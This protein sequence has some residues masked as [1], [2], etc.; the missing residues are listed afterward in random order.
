MV[1]NNFL[2]YFG[3]LIYF[4]LGR[5]PFCIFYKY[6]DS[7]ESWAS[8]SGKQSRT[9]KNLSFDSKENDT[10]ANDIPGNRASR[11]ID[12]SSL[13]SSWFLCT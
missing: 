2:L 8:F 10:Q 13:L 3:L 11:H 9:R 12:V 4:F 6:I 1:A 5:F 7:S